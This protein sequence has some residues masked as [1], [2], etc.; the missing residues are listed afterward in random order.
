VRQQVRDGGVLRDEWVLQ[1]KGRGVTDHRVRPL[2]GLAAHGPAATVEASGLD[3]DAS[4]FR[5]GKQRRQ[6]ARGARR[7]LGAT[8]LALAGAGHQKR[9]PSDSS[10]PEPHNFQ[11]RTPVRVHWTGPGHDSLLRSTASTL[12]RGAGGGPSR[13]L[14][15]FMMDC[16]AAGDSANPSPW[17]VGAV[18]LQTTYLP[19]VTRAQHALTQ[20]QRVRLQLPGSGRGAGQPEHND[21][22]RCIASARSPSRRPK[23]PS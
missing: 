21:I 11:K 5:C 17:V 3:T 20:E 2:Q 8:G 10:S 23:S 14:P 18:E 12:A 15:P 16:T 13:W 22:H 4:W 6:R 9:R 19:V 7:A 1:R